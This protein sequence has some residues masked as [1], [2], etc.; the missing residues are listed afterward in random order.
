MKLPTLIA[1]TVLLT[2]LAETALANPIATE[3]KHGEM[4]AVHNG[5]TYYFANTG[6]RD[7]FVAGFHRSTFSYGNQVPVAHWKTPVEAVI[8]PSG[9]AEQIWERAKRVQAGKDRLL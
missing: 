6:D 7:R 2:A 4:M 1:L 3:S 5:L 8:D 9:K